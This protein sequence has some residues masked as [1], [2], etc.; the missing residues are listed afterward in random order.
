[1]NVG[2]RRKLIVKDKEGERDVMLVGTVSV[3]RDPSCDISANDPALS[4]HHA[5][6]LETARGIL[7]RDLRS[8]NGIKVNNVQVRE[9]V[10]KP[11]DVVTIAA[12]TLRYIEDGATPEAAAPAEKTPET[13]PLGTVVLSGLPSFDEAEDPPPLDEA[14]TP[15]LVAPLVRKPEPA[16]EP[17]AEPPAA[18]APEPVPAPEPEPAPALSAVEALNAD[19]PPPAIDDSTR[20]MAP[21]V[22]VPPPKPL[23]DLIGAPPKPAAGDSDRT[24]VMPMPPR[25]A[26]IPGA[27]AGATSVMQAAASASPAPAAPTRPRVSATQRA[28]QELAATKVKPAAQSSWAARVLLRM[29]LLTLVVSLLSAVPLMIWHQQQMNA[30]SVS[31]ATALVNLLAADASLALST[32]QDL[33]NA[34]QEVLAESGVIAARVL[35]LDGRVLAP[36]SRSNESIASIPGVNAAPNDILRLRSDWNGDRLEVVRPVSAKGSPR[37][38]LAWV[39]INPTTEF[40][41]SSLVVTA[42]IVVISLLLGW[43]VAMLLTRSTQ[44]GFSKLNEDVELALSGGID[45]VRDPIGAKPLGDLTNTINYLLARL[46][47]LGDVAA[48]PA[49]PVPAAGPAAAPSRVTPAAVAPPSKQADATPMMGTPA[50]VPPPRPAAPPPRASEAAPP[51]ATSS[52][53]LGNG[54]VGGRPAAA[55]GPGALGSAASVGPGLG[56]AGFGGGGGL[57]PGAGASAGS[58]AGAGVAG[59]GAG[60]AGIEARLLVDTGF[61]VTEASPGCATLLGTRPDALVGRHLLDAI[62][63]RQ[64]ADAV[65]GCLSALPPAGERQAVTADASGQRLVATVSRPGKDKPITITIR[66]AAAES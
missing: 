66:P 16:P 39:T 33:E 10:L 42:P 36:A 57:G 55:A 29:L 60:S 18:A 63:D 35:S 53:T 45:A 44:R 28:A 59:A 56:A 8:Q 43:I 58:S 14:E 19:A 37:A 2:V 23:A 48:S 34:P 13:S 54:G 51:P 26:P 41:G 9:A 12:L 4:R 1:M 22:F 6:F 61:L 17:V 62:A 65:L 15:P 52:S 7:V 25:G 21:P 49:A 11:G 38:A 64:I 50:P 32:G 31:R 5:E 3:G 40:N 46:R 27:A 30:A 24:N 47:G 20:V